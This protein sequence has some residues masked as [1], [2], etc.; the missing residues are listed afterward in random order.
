[1]KATLSQAA[2][3][4]PMDSG[5]FSRVIRPR[6]GLV[7]ID[8]RELWRFRELLWILSWRNVLIR[9]KQTYIGIA[10]ALLQPF[11]TM[12]V[13]TII[14]GRV[15]KFDSKG[16]PY[17]VMIFAAL[18]PWQFFANALSESSNSLVASQS[19]I[20]KIYFP[21]L[22]IPSSAVLSGMVDFLI[23]F[24]LLLALMGWY[25]VSLNIHFLLL[26]VFFL[27]VSLVSMA[28][29]FWFSALNVK[30]RDV[31]FVVPFIVRIGLYVSPVAFISSMVPAKWRFWYYALNPI[32]GIIDGFRWCIL[33][34]AFEPYWLGFWTGIGVTLAALISGAYY[35]RTTEKTFADII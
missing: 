5:G 15:A 34:P 31:K 21:R 9:Y 12:V 35:F 20:T 6:H 11:L 25:R 30:Y 10:W 8:F 7:A 4:P 33:G 26:P 16:A 1:M 2:E 22:V 23:S 29:G 18:L 17:A 19:M 27:A 14:F 13:M 28:G 24:V 32:A 3:S